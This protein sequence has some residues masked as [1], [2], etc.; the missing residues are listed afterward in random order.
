M[1]LLVPALNKTIKSRMRDK[2]EDWM[3][4]GEGIVD[5][6]AK[7]SSRKLVAE[8]VLEVYNNVPAH[9]AR[10]AWMKRGHEWF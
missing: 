10:N 1:Y 2:W 6:A 5:G 9:I 7:E 8:W 4:E 3:I